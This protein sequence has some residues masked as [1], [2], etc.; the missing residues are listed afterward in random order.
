MSN[1]MSFVLAIA[2]AMA[3]ASFFV[4]RI[5]P[6]AST[7]SAMDETFVRVGLYAETNKSLPPSLNVLPKREGY[8][9]RTTDGWGRGLRYTVAGDGVITLQ[10]LGKDGKPGGEGEN[11]DISRSYR[12]RRP[13]GSLWVGLPMWIVEA[14][15]E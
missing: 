13:D 1:R 10:S 9:N 15:V 11:A 8:L 12:T 6:K 5:P 4:D 2:I 14:K 3:V 7:L